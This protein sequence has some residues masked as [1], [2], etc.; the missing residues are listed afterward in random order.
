VPLVTETFDL[1]PT[2]S[3]TRLTYTGELATDLG[4][5]GERWGDLVARNW[6]GAVENSLAAIR[7]E[8][9]RRTG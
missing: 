7:T 9:E 8:S 5:L 3:G 4:W 1:H 6:I 2:D